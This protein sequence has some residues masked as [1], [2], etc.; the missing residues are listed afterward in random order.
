[1]WKCIR[2]EKE[3]QDTEEIC[4]GV[5]HGRTMDYISHRTL[6]KISISLSENWKRVNREEAENLFRKN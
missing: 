1:M 3:N 5:R 6:A 4:T 2:C